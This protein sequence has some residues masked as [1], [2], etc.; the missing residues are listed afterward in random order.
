[1]CRS[2]GASGAIF[3]ALDAYLIFFPG[4]RILTLVAL[5][6]I[7]RTSRIPAF[8]FIGI[9]LL[10]QSLSGLNSLDPHFA[11]GAGGVA[12]WAHVG[13]FLLGAITAITLRS[14][15]RAKCRPADI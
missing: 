13:G 14:Q 6:V 4:A 2:I 10:I 8:I 1:M 11:A 3:G 7:W 15:P 12:W 5:I 9:W